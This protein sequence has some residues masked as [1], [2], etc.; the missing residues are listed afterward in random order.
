MWRIKS[1]TI[2]LAH[3]GL[4]AGGRGGAGEVCGT[5]CDADADGEGNGGGRKAFVTTDRD[6]C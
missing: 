3:K 2:V 6:T 1:S 5:V 4:G